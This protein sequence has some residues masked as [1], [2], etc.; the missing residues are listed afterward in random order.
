[1]SCAA[2][3]L[4]AGWTS[5]LSNAAVAQLSAK[6]RSRF[7][8]PWLPLIFA[9]VLLIALSQQPGAPAHLLIGDAAISIS[10]LVLA[11]VVTVRTTRDYGVTNGWLYFAAGVG[12]AA[13]II[14]WRAGT[15]PLGHLWQRAPEAYRLAA[16]SSLPLRAAL[17]AAIGAGAGVLPPLRRHLA[18]LS[19]AAARAE[20][21]ADLHRDAELFKL[22]QQFG[23]H[24]LYNSLNSVSALVAVEPDKAQEMIGKLAHFMRA[25]VRRESAQAVPLAD[26]L[27]YVQ[28]YLAI[29]AVRFGDRL[30]VRVEDQRGCEGCVVPPF[31]LQPLL[32]NAIKYGVYGTTGPVEISVD[33]AR[34]GSSLRIIIANPFDPLT[35]PRSGTGFGLEGVGRRLTLL[36]G[37]TDLL[38]TTKADHTFT[39]TLTIPQ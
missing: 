23:P 17:Y 32:E 36:Y 7:S 27:Q 18:E 9:A 8:R 3:A 20:D 16:E 13:G 28:D 39:T 11:C 30:Q 22:R 12:A 29:E 4:W 37:R 33:I 25:S 38:L 14:A 6:S 26:E 10:L 34:I 31:L 2:F 5:S 21:S 35:V 15:Q 24:F 1:M 19:A